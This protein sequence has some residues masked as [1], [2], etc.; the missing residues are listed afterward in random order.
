M[1]ITFAAQMVSLLQQRPTNAVG[2]GIIAL[3]S[4]DVLAGAAQTTGGQAL[5]VICRILRRA[6]HTVQTHLEVENALGSTGCIGTCSGHERRG[7]VRAALAL[8]QEVQDCQEETDDDCVNNHLAKLE[9]HLRIVY[10]FFKSGRT[11]GSPGLLES[12]DDLR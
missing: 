3:L 10:I 7:L 9:R 5:G 11:E 6:S 1:G 4:A 12:L 2:D 8:D